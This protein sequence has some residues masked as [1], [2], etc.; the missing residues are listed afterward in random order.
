[1]GRRPPPP[2]FPHLGTKPQ[3]FPLVQQELSGAGGLVVGAVAVGIGGHM[4]VHE[5]HLAPLVDTAIAVAQVQL[6]L[7]H[8][9]DLGAREHDSRLHPVEQLVIK[10]GLTVVGDQLA[11]VL[12]HWK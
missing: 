12:S 3:D 4:G 9:L 2:L 7:A 5:E 8:A 1:M 6:A 11:L 10:P